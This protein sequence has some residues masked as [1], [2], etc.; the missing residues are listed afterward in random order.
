MLAFL[1]VRFLATA[2]SLATFPR[3][4]VPLRE[5][6]ASLPPQ[7]RLRVVAAAFALRVLFAAYD[8]R[9]KERHVQ[10]GTIVQQPAT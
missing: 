6:M 1:F 4:A 3:L 5:V 7:F 10:L 9:E 8:K 2:A